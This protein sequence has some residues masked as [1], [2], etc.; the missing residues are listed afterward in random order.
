MNEEFVKSIVFASML[1]EATKAMIANRDKYSGAQTLH[2]W[3]HFGDTCGPMFDTITKELIDTKKG[4]LVP[5][6]DF[7]EKPEAYAWGEPIGCFYNPKKGM[8]ELL[9]LIVKHEVLKE[10]EDQTAHLRDDKPQ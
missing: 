2:V 1:E 3:V 8:P 5:A 10:F 9:T 6:K 7:N 4:E